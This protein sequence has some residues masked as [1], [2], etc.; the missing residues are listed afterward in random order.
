MRKGYFY[1]IPKML[2]STIVGECTGTDPRARAEISA[3]DTDQLGQ[4]SSG[5][6][7][8]TGIAA[9]LLIPLL[10]LGFGYVTQHLLATNEAAML[11]AVAKLQGPLH[12][13]RRGGRGTLEQ[14]LHT[15]SIGSGSEVTLNAENSSGALDLIRK[16]VE[17]RKADGTRA[18][19]TVSRSL[20]PIFMAAALGLIPGALIGFLVFRV[21]QAYPRKMLGIAMNELERRTEAE[22]R[23]RTANSLFSAILES[24][25]EGIVAIDGQGR[26][27][28]CNTRYLELWKL[29]ERER[30]QDDDCLL[31]ASLAAKVR[32]PK[33][34]LERNQQLLG[35]PTSELTECLELHDGRSFEWTSRPQR[36]QGEVVGRISTFR[37]VSESKRAEVLLSTEK[38]VLEKV[39]RGAPLED[40]LFVVA[41]AIER[42]SG[43]MFCAIFF[44]EDGRTTNL[45]VVTGRSLPSWYR[46]QLL[47]LHPRIGQHKDD[48]YCINVETPGRWF[49]SRA[50]LRLMEQLAVSQTNLET[51]RGSTGDTIGLVLAHYRINSDHGFER[52]GQL[53]HIASQMCAIAIDRYRSTR[54]LDLLAHY[55]FLTGLPN[56]K[57]FH[58]HLRRA[59][60]RAQGTNRPLGLLFLD[61]DRFKAVNDSLGH[62]AGDALLKVAASRIRECVRA[63]DVVARLSGDEFVVLIEDLQRTEIAAGLARKIAARMTEGVSLNGHETFISASVGI[64]LYPKD[65]NTLE[66]LLKN[67]D[68]AMYEVKGQGRN[69]VQFFHSRMNEGG[70]ERLQLEGQLRR[71]LERN[72]MAIH[73][74]PK[75]LASTS[76][77]VGAEALLRWHHP[78]QGL[79]LP[80]K[81]VPLLEETGLI[82]DFWDWIIRQVCEDML[83]LDQVSSRRIDIAV[84]VSARQFGKRRLREGLM[85]AVDATGVDPGRLELEL[86]ESLLMKEPQQ[87][88]QILYELRELGVGGIAIDDFGTGYSSLAYLKRFPITGLKIDR[89]FVSGIAQSS[90]DG[91][92]VQ[93]ILALARSLDLRVT[94]EG[95]E[96]LEQATSLTVQGCH[97]LQGYYFGKPVSLESF[98]EALNGVSARSRLPVDRE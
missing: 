28:A 84:N 5:I 61:L 15:I 10:V 79:M 57:R 8:F 21:T 70:L 72:E 69:G 82:V 9:G 60:E 32:D 64:A 7:W 23:L 19:L 24:T 18:T 51:I 30:V 86:T 35:A 14:L 90:Q 11:S 71:V 29:S 31:F 96:T 80:S 20:Q 78:E 34:F 27:V 56:R 50:Y 25:A 53:L 1:L 67:A 36:I 52:D 39:V 2:S 65:G 77:I 54:E 26:I 49:E 44:C 81:F 95:V 47:A 94:A 74:Q 59:I 22:H 92:I 37:D 62:A 13:P 17:V 73:Y 46:D 93:A 97:E 89:S 88:S 6:A 45:N 58:D 41:D 76:A 55:D 4:L 33:A 43:D 68:A 87:A 3:P 16:R 63:H 98:V 85:R 48:S 66:D 75:V 38:A 42:E 83:R 40:A 91:A 12:F